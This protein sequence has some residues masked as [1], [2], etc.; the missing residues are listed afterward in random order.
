MG[1]LHVSSALLLLLP[2]VCR[3]RCSAISVS[4]CTPC[5]MVLSALTVAIGV[6]LSISRIVPVTVTITVSIVIAGLADI[7]SY[8]TVSMAL[9]YFF[10]ATHLHLYLL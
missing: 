4:F 3:T 7:S 10:L 1:N 6:S 2:D 5:L 8:K 9:Q